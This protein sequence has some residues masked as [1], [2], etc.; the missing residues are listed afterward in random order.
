MGN[1]PCHYYSFEGFKGKVGFISAISHKFC[2]ECNRIRLTSQGFLKTCLQYNTGNDLKAPL[3]QGA[4]D[5]ELKEL[6][7][8]TIEGKPIGHRFLEQQIEDENNLNM[9]QIGG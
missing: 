5:E 3:R 7:R 4:L 9:S 8:T 6:I 1:G 2:N